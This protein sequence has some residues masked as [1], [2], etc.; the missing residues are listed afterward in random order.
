M[1][2]KKERGQVLV[3]IALGMVAI[4]GIVAVAVDGG[5][6]FAER[7]RSQNAADN[8]ALAA[9]YAICKKT[10]PVAAGLASAA[11]NGYDN[12]GASNTVTLNHPPLSGAHLGDNEYSEAIVDS[13]RTTFFAQL[14]GFNDLPVTTRAVSH[15][16]LS[17]DYAVLALT[18]RNDIH[19]LEVTG[20]GSLN[21][22]GGGIMSDSTHPTQ[23]LYDFGSGSITA[24]VIHASGGVTCDGVCN[25]P[26]EGGVPY[27]PDPLASLPP[28][29][30]QPQ[31]AQSTP[32]ASPT[33]TTGGGH[34]GLAVNFNGSMNITLNPGMYCYIK[35]GSGIHYIL[36]PGIY[37]IDGAG[38]LGF[39]IQI[40]GDSTITGSNVMFYL[41]PNAGMVD[42]HGNAY[43]NI[44]SCRSTNPGA[45]CVGSLSI[46]SGM[47]FFADRSY[48]KSISMI[49]NAHWD[50]TGTIYAAGSNLDL[51][52]NGVDNNLS[53]MIIAYTIKLGG[54]ANTVV[55][56]DPG[57]NITPPASVSLV[58]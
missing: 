49:G 50:A 53:S 32:T 37:Y 58:D 39:G 33:C 28:P 7:R 48:V 27:V 46:Y 45:W 31:P 23:A 36:N 3:L 55:N 22:N 30:V 57:L 18:T 24:E 29:A 44:S 38:P 16:R 6:L 42:M 10:D 21:V 20:T 15:C 4:V 40:T 2:A 41:S 17:F 5:Q 34:P 25:P 14:I 13:H 56:Y 35:G 54:D 51:S 47:L 19:G 1:S 43:V 26:A 52:G 12:D 11:T 9:A 8:A